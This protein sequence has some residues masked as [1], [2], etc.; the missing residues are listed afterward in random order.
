M[1]EPEFA[2]PGGSASAPCPSSV[3]WPIYQNY[4]DLWIPKCWKIQLHQQGILQ[5]KLARC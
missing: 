4:H 5:S 3:H 2:V 1:A